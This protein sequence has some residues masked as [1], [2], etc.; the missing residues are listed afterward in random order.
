MELIPYLD[1]LLPLLEVVVAELMVME[2]VLLEVLA[3]AL[4]GLLVTTQVLAHLVKVA[5]AEKIQQTQFYKAV[6]VGAVLVL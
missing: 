3:G 6:A 5:Q 4:H 1:L 2:A